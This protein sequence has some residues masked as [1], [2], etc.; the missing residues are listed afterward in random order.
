MF[1][2][3]VNS[4]QVSSEQSHQRNC[5]LVGQV[6]PRNSAQQTR[7]PCLKRSMEEQNLI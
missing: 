4:S 3:I 6:A 2:H 7:S 5:L 1:H